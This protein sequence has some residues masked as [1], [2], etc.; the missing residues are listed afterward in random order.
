MSIEGNIEGKRIQE[1]IPRESGRGS[2]NHPN[3]PRVRI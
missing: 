2:A 1:G 3:A